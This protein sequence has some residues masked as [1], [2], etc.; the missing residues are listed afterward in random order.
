MEKTITRVWFSASSD[1]GGTTTGHI[2][3][4]F[5]IGSALG[6]QKIDL[7]ADD[8]GAVLASAKAK[9]IAKLEEDGST[10]VDGTL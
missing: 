7:T 3:A 5:N 4:K 9:A 1:E 8:M 6:H 10:V 2:Q